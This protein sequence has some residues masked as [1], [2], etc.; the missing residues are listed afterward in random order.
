MFSGTLRHRDIECVVQEGGAYSAC[1]Y[2]IRMCAKVVGEPPPSGCV[3]KFRTHFARAIF[4]PKQTTLVKILATPLNYKLYI[5]MN[6]EIINHVAVTTYTMKR[7]PSAH[8]S[9]TQMA[10]HG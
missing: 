4:P 10:R 8:L 1:T 2:K 3:Q 5:R 9:G 6:K 7:M